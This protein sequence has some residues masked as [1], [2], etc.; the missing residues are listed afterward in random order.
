MYGIPFPVPVKAVIAMGKN[1]NVLL[2]MMTAAT[3]SMFILEGHNMSGLSETNST[4]KAMKGATEAL[5]NT[6]SIK[7]DRALG[8]LN[9]TLLLVSLSASHRILF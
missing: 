1:L 5:F 2:M 8:A 3:T 6:I 7:R 4:G 9:G